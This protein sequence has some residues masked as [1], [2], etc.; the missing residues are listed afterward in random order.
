MGFDYTPFCVVEH[1]KLRA[2]VR[3]DCLS[4]ASSAAPLYA[5]AHRAAAG[6]HGRVAFLL[7]HFLWISKEKSLAIEGEKQSKN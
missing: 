5:E 7:D 4:A 6:Q 1:W 3:E 2:E